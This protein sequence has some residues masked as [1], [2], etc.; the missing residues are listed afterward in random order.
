[1]N[2]PAASAR[3]RLLSLRRAGNKTHCLVLRGGDER[4]T[5]HQVCEL[6]A[7]RSLAT[8]R[9]QQPAASYLHNYWLIDRFYW[10]A[11][12]LTPRRRLTSHSCCYSLCHQ[13]RTPRDEQVN[14]I[15]RFVILSAAFN[16][17]IQNYLI[18]CI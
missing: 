2:L 18:D 17:Q 6:R 9:C 1:M 15:Y 14:S 16:T 13:L 11:E 12:S 5:N 7:A 8:L 4:A 3:L 10:R